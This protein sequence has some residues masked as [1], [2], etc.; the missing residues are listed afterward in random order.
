MNVLPS[1]Q[2]PHVAVVGGGYMGT[3]MAQV[4]ALCGRSVFLCD[5][6]EELARAAAERAVN[7]AAKYEQA[8]LFPEGSSEAI[9]E[10]VSPAASLENAVADAEYIAEV[11][12]ERRDV[13]REVLERISAA[14]QESVIT[15]NTSAIP[16]SELQRWVLNPERFAG[17]H[18]MNPAPF[19]PCVEVIAGG[20]TS[21]ET[22]TFVTDLM[23]IAGKQPVRVSDVAGFVANRL[24]FALFQEAARMVDD[25]VATPQ[26]ID[27][28]VT[29][30]FGF[31]LPF[32]GPFRAADMAGLDVYVGAYES[33]EAAFGERFKPP[34]ALTSL[35]NEG[36]LGIKTQG[37]FTVS[38]GTNIEHLLAYRN[39]AYSGLT[40]LKNHLRSAPAAPT[41]NDK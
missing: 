20:L 21:E 4:F 5:V 17:A 31:R 7:E 33:L 14:N 27:E 26:V 41:R 35:V 16:I 25:G 30:S 18:W 9:R 12:P 8:G 37:G 11:V 40:Q 28:V 29:G 19:V 13:K 1:L 23:F 36:L 39:A 10:R 34:A 6:T 2:E 22:L 15:S 24:Q 32:I 38:S 3:G